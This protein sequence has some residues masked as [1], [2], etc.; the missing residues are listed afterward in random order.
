MLSQLEDA[1]SILNA[2][3][4]P[5]AYPLLSLLIREENR[6]LVTGSADGQV[7][8]VPGLCFVLSPAVLG[9]CPPVHLSTGVGLGGLGSAALTSI[10]MF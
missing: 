2:L 7:R 1:L 4:S 9:L 10:C 5:S 8:R 6:Q 3:C